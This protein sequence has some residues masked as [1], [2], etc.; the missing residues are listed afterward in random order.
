MVMAEIL[1]HAVNSGTSV[2]KPTIRDSLP[3]DDV[4]LPQTGRSF[5]AQATQATRRYKEPTTEIL[6]A[7]MKVATVRQD[8]SE[9]KRIFAKMRWGMIPYWA[10]NMSIGAVGNFRMLADISH[11][12]HRRAEPGRTTS[13]SI[14]SAIGGSQEAPECSFKQLG[15]SKFQGK[16]E[17]LAHNDHKAC[18][19]AR[20]V[21]L[22]AMPHKTR[23]QLCQW[24]HCRH[25]YLHKFRHTFATEHLRHGVDIRTVQQWMGH[26][27][28]QST[29]VYLRGLESKDAHAKINAGSLAAYVALP[30]TKSSP[31]EATYSL[32]QTEFS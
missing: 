20:R 18:S 15:F 11:R 24:P 25:F 30:H 4:G 23:K 3:A 9:P 22:R 5:A 26:R 12:G 7:L 10:K 16:S 14:D 17:R 8:R 2:E 1:L 27:D 6:R 13:V 29:M 21:E 32:I 28:I 31:P 19:R